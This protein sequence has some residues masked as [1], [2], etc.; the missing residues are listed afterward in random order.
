M[1]TITIPSEKVIEAAQATISN[2]LANRE[3]RDAKAV[4][5]YIAQSTPG[6]LARFFGR[7]PATPERAKRALREL[8]FGDYPSC[9]GW[10][11]LAHARKL[12]KVA[13]HGDPVTLN[14]EDVRVL[15]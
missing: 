5:A 6:P 12:L 1:A 13:E 4:Q 11:D 14:E 3:A 7:K 15:F 8:T 2:I 10:G 9:A